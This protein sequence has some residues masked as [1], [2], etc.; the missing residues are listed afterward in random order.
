[1]GALRGRLVYKS[2]MKRAIFFTIAAL[3]GWQVYSQYRAGALA[4]F[5]PAQPTG[6]VAVGAPPAGGFK[7][8]QRTECSQMTSC[9]EAKFF[10]KNCPDVDLTLD[11]SGVPCARRWCTTPDAP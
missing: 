7:C 8:D 6:P 1:L 9:A 5:M 2:T 3:L 10:L 11:A 4:S